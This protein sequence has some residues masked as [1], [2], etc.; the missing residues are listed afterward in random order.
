MAADLPLTYLFVPGNRPERFGKAAACGAQAV[1]LDLEDA[2]APEHKLEAREAVDR[3]LAARQPGGV[4]V[5]VRIND[6]S[7]PWFADELEW[8]ARAVPDGVM[9]P[10]A[11]DPELLRRVRRS[12]PTACALV[13]L[14]ETASGVAQARE[15]SEVAGVQRLAFG[16]I[17][18]ALDLDLP[19]DER[20]LL[21][22]ASVLAIESRRAGLARPIAGVTAALD[23]RV[24][25]L[26]DWGFARATGFGAKM[27]IHPAQVLALHQAMKPDQAELDWARRVVAAAQASPGAARVNGRM[28][29]KPVLL[30]AQALLARA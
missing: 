26:A 10:K 28:V 5:L 23:D 16:T 30:K 11:E 3:W 19:D 20:G 24:R 17:D 27:C 14:V 21:H 12:L 13:P 15:L 25:L 22:A 18:Y 4:P 7:T 29:D 6:C 9:L 2:V 8:L 1:I